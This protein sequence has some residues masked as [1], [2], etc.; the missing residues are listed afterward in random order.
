MAINDPYYAGP[1]YDEPTS[2]QRQADMNLLDNAMAERIVRLEMQRAL[3]RINVLLTQRT[4]EV[5]W[6]GNFTMQR[7][8]FRT[9]QRYRERVEP[10][11][12]VDALTECL[13]DY[14]EHLPEDVDE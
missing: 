9:E 5:L 7:F 4:P 10:H 6:D 13:S 3:Y 1:A 11:D 12:V 2:A 8:D 14:I